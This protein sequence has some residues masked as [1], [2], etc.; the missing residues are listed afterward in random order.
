M[1]KSL[2]TRILLTT[3]NQLRMHKTKWYFYV[4]CI[5]SKTMP[6]IAPNLGVSMNP[7]FVSVFH[8][9]YW[10]IILLSPKSSPWKRVRYVLSQLRT[11]FPLQKEEYWLY[12]NF[13]QSKIKCSILLL[14][15]K[16]CYVHRLCIF[17]ITNQNIGTHLTHPSKICLCLVETNKETR[18]QLS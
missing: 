18:I 5:L 12:N 4:W 2:E 7:Q 11:N 8:W 3:E 9:F 13:N 16:I 10:T 15:W 14:L 1:S 6:S 17:F